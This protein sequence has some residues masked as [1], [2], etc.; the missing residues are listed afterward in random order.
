M[1]DFV[2]VF[3]IGFISGIISL[4]VGILIFS[5][6]N[7]KNDPITQHL[8]KIGKKKVIGKGKKD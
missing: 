2:F 1:F 3:V 6:I 4:I 8:I 7:W 5:Y